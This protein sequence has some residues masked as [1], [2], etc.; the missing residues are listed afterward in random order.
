MSNHPQT[1]R[2]PVRK[3]PQ[4]FNVCSKCRSAGF[5]REFVRRCPCGGLYVSA[6]G[7]G[8]W[9]ECRFCFARGHIAGERCPAC[10]GDGWVHVGPHRMS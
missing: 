4:P 9:Q 10:R 2:D 3:Q 1:W 7:S 6:L 8:D 5:E